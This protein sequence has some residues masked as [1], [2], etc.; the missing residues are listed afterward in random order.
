M[1]RKT[2]EMGRRLG[3][4]SFPGKRNLVFSRRLRRLGGP[5]V[6]LV[7]EDPAVVGERLRRGSGKH[8][9]LVGG[10]E[11]IAAFLDAGQVDEL[12]VHVI[13]VL[14]GEGIP[15]VAPRHRTVPLELLA[16][17]SFSDGVVR[18][19]YAVR[20]PAR[21]AAQR[22]PAKAKARSKRRTRVAA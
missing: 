3:Q 2:Y 18:L 14:I 8:V 20:R 21:S 22:Q 9:W 6:E 7:R 11:L 5:G 4:D 1:G 16:S 10:A 12:I 13:P 15:L 17:R 19:R